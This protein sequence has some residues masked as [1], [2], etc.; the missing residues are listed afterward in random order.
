M[1]NEGVGG[2][3]CKHPFCFLVYGH[4]NLQKKYYFANQKACR[5]TNFIGMSKKRMKFRNFFGAAILLKAA[6]GIFCCMLM[7]SLVGV[8][9]TEYSFKH[10][11]INQGLS[12]NQINCM[13][14]DSKG[15]MWFGTASGLN[16]YDG[17]GFKI[18]THSDTDATSIIENS[19]IDIQEDY[20]ENLWVN[21]GAGLS[22]FFP[23]T[24]KF[25]FPINPYLSS[26]GFTDSLVLVFIDHQ[27]N[28]WL[29][30]NQQECFN[31]SGEENKWQKV[32]AFSGKTITD[33]FHYDH[34]VYAVFT[35]GQIVAVNTESLEGEPAINIPLLTGGSSVNSFNIYVDT[36]QDIWLFQETNPIGAFY[37][38]SRGKKWHHLTN[39]AGC[40]FPLSSNTVKD[41]VED[42]QKLIWIAT[43]HGGINVINKSI[44]N[45]VYLENNPKDP[46]S[47][48]EKSIMCLYCDSESILWAGTYKYGISYYSESIFKFN[49]IRFNVSGLEAEFDNDINNF[50]EDLEGNLWIGSNNKG[51]IRIDNVTKKQMLFQHNPNNPQSISNNVVV[52]LTCDRKG[53]IWAGT[54]Q[55]GLNCYDGGRFIHYRNQANNANSIASD[56]VW[57]IVED[58]QGNLWI[59]TLGGGIDCF[60]VQT[61]FFKHHTSQTHP[62]L[63]SDYVLCIQETKE[64]NLLLGT[65]HGVSIYYPKTGTFQIIQGNF[66]GTKPLTNRN[67]LSVYEDSRGLIWVGTRG[68]L[69]I[70]N[71]KNDD[72]ILLN[73]E[74]GIADNVICGILEDDQKNI[75]I[76]TANGLSHIVLSINPKTGEY[77]FIPSNYDEKD[78]LQGKAFN[79]RSAYKTS[80]GEIL[81]GGTNGYNSVLPANIKY[82]RNRPNLV[83]TNFLLFNKPVFIDSVYQKRK[84]LEKSISNTILIELEHN[85]NIFTIEFSALNYLLPDKT[86]YSYKMEG[87]DLNW[88]TISGNRHSATYTNLNPGKYTFKV[89]AANN[90]GYWTEN[91]IE[92]NL[93]VHPPFWRSTWAYILYYLLITGLLILSGTFFR[94]RVKMR[95]QLAQERL[96]AKRTRELDE[97]KLR[98]FTN[99]SHE[100]RTQISLIIIPLEKLIKTMDN[101]EDKKALKLINRNA[102][103]L[104]QLVNQ[105]LDFRKMDVQGHKLNLSTGDIVQ[106]IRETCLSFAEMY[107]KKNMHLTFSSVTEE[108]RM[109]FDEDKISKIINNLLSNAYKFTPVGG[110]IDVKLTLVNENNNHQLLKVSVADN[111]IGVKDEDKSRIFERFYQVNTADAKAGS[112]IGLHLS[113]EY[114][115]LHGG[116]IWMENNGA[117]GSIFI[118]TI[119]M[120]N[121]LLTDFERHELV[122]TLSTYHEDELETPQAT[123]DGTRKC[124]LVVEDNEDFRNFI[125]SSLLEHYD[126][127]E[128]PNGKDAFEII[129]HK[130]PDLVISDVMMPEMDGY[131]LCKRIKNDMRSSHIPVILLTAH[132]AKEHIVQG[133]EL[134]ADEYITKPF[135]FDILLLRINKLLEQRAEMHYQIK[136]KREINPSEINISSLD[137]KLIES[138]IKCVEENM[139]NPDF[140]VEMLSHEMSMSRVH[141]YKKLLSIT[142]KT[143]IE[144]IR[145][146]RLKRAAQ[147]LGKS[148]L[149]VSEIAYQVGFNNPKYFSRYFKEEFGLLPSVYAEKHKKG[150]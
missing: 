102:N 15:F 91:P 63:A 133:L 64:K 25:I 16:R 46:R 149:S 30:N 81:F 87:F 141:L 118:F 122:E 132:T 45:V 98:F 142:G 23:E 101:E 96:E 37:F 127:L 99:I 49:H 124:V 28:F 148:Q 22:I 7:P 74:S 12:N 9:Q 71:P 150:N 139:D 17:N 52:S 1:K 26:L 112:G 120:V 138:A 104:L 69:N 82:N 41:I 119:P 146:I 79:E 83:F 105:L 100:F 31:Y 65:A 134:G 4:P 86:I 51:L 6:F 115:K 110:N 117:Q 43:D 84:I 125:C 34:W 97:M 108:I 126:V 40:K 36:D 143:P 44:E 85:Q 42:T 130:L 53:R 50:Q 93:V 21:T 60:D 80:S 140:S 29:T 62:G 73:E 107:E 137:E 145:I 39:S 18:F 35:D 72:L 128:A 109:N 10:L 121:S 8:S 24:E 20:Q 106:F 61:G 11:T 103:K 94:R 54:Y 33:F 131:E 3:G 58:N 147:L 90:D 111:G 114:V 144:F 77:N 57:D 47:L 48:A 88:T 89:K 116:E 32:E 70:I 75:W 78:G 136:Q 66:S 92:L 129:V 38:S 59:A 135:N 123:I 67:V 95:F 2:F 56:L 113:K 27:K 68:G 13:F 19:I 5:A 55:G 14:R 76:S